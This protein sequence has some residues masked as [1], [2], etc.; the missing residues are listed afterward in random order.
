MPDLRKQI[1]RLAHENP[2]LRE[3]LLPLIKKA[4]DAER[5]RRMRELDPKDPGVTKALQRELARGGRPIPEGKTVE[6]GAIRVHRFRSAF[7]VWDLTN[8][9]RRGKMVDHFSLHYLDKVSQFSDL[10]D[11][12]SASL[13]SANYQRALANAKRVMQTVHDAN[14]ST[15]AP[16]I[17]ELQEKGVR[18][19]P[20]GQDPIEVQNSGMK[21]KVEPQDFFFRDLTDKHNEPAIQPRKRKRTGTKKLYAW[22][23]KNQDELAKMSFSD[24]RNLLKNLG[25]DYHYWAMMD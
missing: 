22:A 7:Q 24:V 8:A 1:I 5:L 18:V 9:G 21:G 16:G 15:Y 4:Y 2:E 17:Q 19:D 13:R 3:D 10:F 25:I 23:V 12:Y 20:P 14:N 11:A 6:N